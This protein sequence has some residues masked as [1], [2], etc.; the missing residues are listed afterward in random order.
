MRFLGEARGDG[1]RF[2]HVFLISYTETRGKVQAGSI[3][4]NALYV[5][6][7]LDTTECRR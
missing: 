2:H 4:H 1:K 6:V 3:E 7:M 5:V